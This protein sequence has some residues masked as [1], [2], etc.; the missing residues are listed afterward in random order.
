MEKSQSA[1]PLFRGFTGPI[2][3]LS[4]FAFCLGLAACNPNRNITQGRPQ[5]GD[6]VK[7]EG[8]GRPLKQGQEPGVAAPSPRA[9]SDGE[10]E[11]E[12]DERKPPG[13]Y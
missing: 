9:R 12:L 7:A 8:M 6:V 2:S 3:L 5:G 11:R 1:Q 10:K 4:L 13:S